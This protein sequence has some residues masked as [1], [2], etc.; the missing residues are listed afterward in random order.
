MTSQIQE[1][2]F[3]ACNMA[4]ISQPMK[5]KLKLASIYSQTDKQNKQENNVVEHSLTYM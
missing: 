2:I 4:V 3:V 1:R 5:V